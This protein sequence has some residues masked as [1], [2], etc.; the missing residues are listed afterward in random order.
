MKLSHIERP[1]QFGPGNELFGIV[2]LPASKTSSTRPMVVMLN[3]GIIHRAG[4]NRTHV[5]LARTFA[6]HG[7]RTLRFDLSGIGE[8]GRRGGVMSLAEAVQADVTNAF[9]YLAGKYQA[10]SFVLMG[11]CS[12]A[13][14]ALQLALQD[15]RVVGVAA[16]DVPAAMRNF[17]HFFVHYG[18]RLLR[19]TSWYNALHNPTNAVRGMVQMIAPGI[20]AP[21]RIDM[22]VRPVQSLS[23]LDATLRELTVRNVKSIFLFTSGIEMNYNYEHQFRDVLP[24]HATH[25]NVSYGFFAQADHTFNRLEDRRALIVR[26][27]EWFEQTSFKPVHPRQTEKTTHYSLHQADPSGERADI[28]AI[29]QGNLPEGTGERYERIYVSNPCGGSW[30][31]LACIED[32][33]GRSGTPVGT[34]GLCERRFAVDGKSCVAGVALDFAVLEP[35][36]GFGPALKLQ[37]AVT[38]KCAEEN[39]AF[40]YGYPNEQAESVFKMVGYKTV[41][42][43]TRWVK[44]LRSGYKL[45]E[46]TRSKA[47]SSIISWVVDPVLLLRSRET[48]YRAARSV[49]TEVRRSFDEGFNKL[50]EESERRYAIL[51]DRSADYL[52]WR[53]AGQPD[54]KTFCL[55]SDPGSTLLG[56]VVYAAR[57]EVSEVRDLMSADPDRE[58]D[59]LIAEFILHMRRE[60]FSAVSLSYLG[61]PTVADSFKRWGFVARGQRKIMLYMNEPCVQAERLLDG[62]NWHL[63]DG[64]DI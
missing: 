18:R 35:H 52:N 34:T 64:D 63:L 32:E 4:A 15:P 61:H 6:E 59:T 20:G 38:G 53:Y 1:V 27:T 29:W 19:R 43:A 56:Y 36:R 45:R 44:V 2:C 13:H 49:R 25:P 50:W 48:R 10:D 21:G 39:L 28:L 5:L 55:L 23:E 57:G 3:S 16:I 17:R 12:G 30:T 42:V 58:L 31:W 9:D 54:V 14:D 51:G 33:N 7:I 37:R 41:G 40:L 26:L 11:L 24:A 47:L 62:Q 46:M 22:G 60:R 8:S